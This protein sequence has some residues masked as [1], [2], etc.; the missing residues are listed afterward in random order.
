MEI[1][2]EKFILLDSL[3]CKL[4][5]T[6]EKEKALLAVPEVCADKIITLY[7][8]SLFAGYK[9]VIKTYL[10]IS[11]KLSIPNL[12]HYLRSYL[13]ACHIF[14]LVRNE[15]PHSRQLQTRIY[16]NYRLVSRLSMDL[17]AMPKSPKGHHYILCI[18]DEVTNYLVTALLYQARSE[19]VGE[20]LIESIV[21]KFGSPEYMIMDQ[22]IM[23][24]STLM[25]YLFK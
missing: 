9:G 8:V 7:H 19:E 11:D 21:S 15:K 25:N 13:K 16:L 6:P 5:P 12:M 22:D 24:I 4:V 1:L 3:L 23:F 14:Q 2:S 20:A 10:T 17:K 18:I